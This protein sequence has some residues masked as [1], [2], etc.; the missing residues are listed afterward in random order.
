MPTQ[1]TQSNQDGSQ[2]FLQQFYGGGK[3]DFQ[4]VEDLVN[5]FSTREEDKLTGQLAAQDKVQEG[6]DYIAEQNYNKKIQQEEAENQKTIEEETK[7]QAFQEQPVEVKQMGGMYFV[8]DP[9][10]GYNQSMMDY[11]QLI[12]GGYDKYLKSNPFDLA[13]QMLFK[14]SVELHHDEELPSEFV[15]DVMMLDRTHKMTPT[16]NGTLIDNIDPFM[17]RT[18]ELMAQNFKEENPV[19]EKPQSMMFY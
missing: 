11:Q 18:I 12:E 17:H 14:E 13:W 1:S 9:A 19:E 5:R 2:D 4:D 16:N 8:T 10:Y 3:K 7:E 15:D 6:R